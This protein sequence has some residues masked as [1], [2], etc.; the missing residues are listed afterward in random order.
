MAALSKAPIA[1]T[2]GDGILAGLEKEE[3][4]LP[5]K[6]LVSDIQYFVCVAL[7]NDCKRQVRKLK[8][9]SKSSSN[10]RAARI[11]P[12]LAYY[13][14]T[15]SHSGIYFGTFQPQ[16]IVFWPNIDIGSD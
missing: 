9:D 5:P 13:G 3:A 4:S 1:N 14:L 8:H 7:P 15:T 16:K 12:K 10:L 2:D 6:L 11:A